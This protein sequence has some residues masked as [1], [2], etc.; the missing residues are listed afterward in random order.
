MG[1]LD[2][3]KGSIPCPWCGTQ[4]AK[5][6]GGKV[7]CPNPNC[8]NFDPALQ[9]R[10]GAASASGPIIRTSARPQGFKGGGSF[11]PA[12][13]LTV[14]YRNHAGEEK[15]FTA[16]AETAQRKKNHIV[17]HVAPTG[18]PLTLSRDRILNLAEV[19]GSF[20]QRVA[21]DQPWP[22]AKERQVLNYHKK[23]G[24]TS[25]LHEKIRAKYPNW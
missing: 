10:G 2:F 25:P 16:D 21:P 1:F 8:S 5:M 7:R 22:T 9:A 15:T 17:V 4:G 23:H 14:R 13:P 20:A 11:T 18:A 19:E 12:R 6:S 3:L 24:S